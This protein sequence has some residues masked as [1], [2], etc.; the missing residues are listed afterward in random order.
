M[1]DETKSIMS[2]SE[3]MS[4]SRIPPASKM[5]LSSNTAL[6]YITNKNTSS[7]TQNHP[8]SHLASNYN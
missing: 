1:V 6:N 7:I 8:A 3:D 4:S 5:N 2:I